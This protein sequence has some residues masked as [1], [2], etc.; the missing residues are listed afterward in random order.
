MRP[1]VEVGAGVGG[2]VRW[3]A[4]GGTRPGSA[5]HTLAASRPGP[6]DL[7]LHL[8]PPG[9]DKFYPKGKARR[10]ATDKGKAAEGEGGGDKGGAGGGGRPPD[11]PVAV[12]AKQLGQLALLAAVMA[13][14]SSLTDPTPEVQEARGGSVLVEGGGEGGRRGGAAAARRPAIP[15]AHAAPH[16]SPPWL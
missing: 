10:P 7:P 3:A 13:G 9:F 2:Y 4:A 12:L 8:P 5:R 15:F 1:P 16:S 11:T 6:P 14:V